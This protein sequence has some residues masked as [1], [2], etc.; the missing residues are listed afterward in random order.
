MRLAIADPPYLGRAD[1][2]YG[3]G[4]GSG[5]VTSVPGRPAKKP[6][7]HPEAAQW[8]SLGKHLTL[9]AELAETYDGWAIAGT[10]ESGALLLPSAPKGSRIAPWVRTNAMP[11]GARVINTWESVVF[12]VPP[13]RRERIA[14]QSVRDALVTSVPDQKFLGS[15]PAEW[16]RWVL[17]MLG[18]DPQEDEVD[19]IFTG[20]GAVAA[21]VDGMLI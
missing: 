2:W 11:A 18:Y 8:D 14:G 7:Y 15:K 19:D 12:Y 21:A 13:S 1:R 10:A 20:S 4:R 9:M 16:T 17:A 5:R 6:D 3:N